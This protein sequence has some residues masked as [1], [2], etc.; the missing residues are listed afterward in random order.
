MSDLISRQDALDA[1]SK[2]HW[3]SVEANRSQC[4]PWDTD[5]QTLTVHMDVAAVRR[6]IADVPATQEGWVSVKERL[7]ELD[8]EVLVY[9]V[10]KID[11]FIDTH[12]YAICNRFVQHILPSSPGYERWSTPWE[13]FHMDYEITH[14]MPIPAGPKEGDAE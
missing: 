3:F 5:I 4:S 11:G 1:V 8:Q 13:Y 9:A 14:W 6:A 7:P 10:G 12:V 2:V